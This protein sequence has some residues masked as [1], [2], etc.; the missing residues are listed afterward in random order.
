MLMLLLLNDKNEQKLARPIWL[1]KVMELLNDNWN[2]EIS[3]RDLATEA[4][5]H[6]KTISK[7][8]PKYFACTLGEHRRKIKV[9]ERVKLGEHPYRV[10]FT[11]DG[12]FL[13]ATMP[14]TK[15]LIVI[16]TATRNEVKRIKLESTPLGL[17]FSK[18][19]KTAFVTATQNDFVLK[20]DIEKGEI[21]GKVAVG[22]NPDGIALIGM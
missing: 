5:I 7:Y 11:P 14:N 2:D 6:P 12:K 17:I 18:D 15:E 13:M 9:V 1:K 20:I 10:R 16:D 19:G 3:L 21:I 22:K 4:S 8:F